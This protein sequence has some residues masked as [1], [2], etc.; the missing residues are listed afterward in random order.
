LAPAARPR[1]VAGRDWRVHRELHVIR[2]R[3]VPFYE[4]NSDN[5]RL[6]NNRQEFGF[7]IF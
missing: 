3:S 7:E 2:D 4:I 6:A 5:R 1:A